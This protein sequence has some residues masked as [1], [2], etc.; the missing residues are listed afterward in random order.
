MSKTEHGELKEDVSPVSVGVIERGDEVIL[1]FDKAVSWIIIDP[2]QAI[3]IAEKL[4]A[5]ALGILRKQAGS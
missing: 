3:K 5:E 2:L 1:E 4:K